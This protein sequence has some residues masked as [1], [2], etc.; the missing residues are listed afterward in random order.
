MRVMMNDHSP[1][2]ADLDRIKIPMSSFAGELA[3]T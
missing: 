3:R 1:P 2:S